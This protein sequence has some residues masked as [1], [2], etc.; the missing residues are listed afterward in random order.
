GFA[1][2]EVRNIMGLNWLRLLE[3]ATTAIA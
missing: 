2:E 1:E 3:T